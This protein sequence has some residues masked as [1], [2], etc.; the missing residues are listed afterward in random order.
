M[1][2]I[3]KMALVWA[4]VFASIPFTPQEHESASRRVVPK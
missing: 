4:F 1:I 3:Q 2:T